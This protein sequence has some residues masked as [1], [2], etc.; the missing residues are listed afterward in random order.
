MMRRANTMWL[1]TC[2]TTILTSVLIVS[3]AASAQTVID[4]IGAPRMRAIALQTEP[5][6]PLSA[7][8]V[9]LLDNVADAINL[10]TP[11]LTE[12]RFRNFLE[13]QR[14][15]GRKAV[16]GGYIDY[17]LRRAMTQASPDA[18]AASERVTFYAAQEAA[19]LQHLSLL[20]KERSAREGSRLP[21]FVLRE[22]VLGDFDRDDDPVRNG[23][24]RNVNTD[25]LPGLIAQWRET[26]KQ[27]TDDRTVA[28]RDFD[29]AARADAKLMQR[30]SSANRD[31][32]EVVR[33][34]FDDT[35]AH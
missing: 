17:V 4:N 29:A 31:L 25:E 8:Y 34:V 15:A 14:D 16:P 7:P 26:L 19:I 11:S 9:Q 30:I 35:P 22:P 2:E 27:V 10:D 21:D 23:L 32:N 13:R 5:P 18:A 20:E 33:T 1:R 6:G 12:T 24:P 3:C 28:V